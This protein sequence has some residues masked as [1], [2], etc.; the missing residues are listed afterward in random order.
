MA[1]LLTC[2]A[3]S[4]EKVVVVCPDGFVTTLDI[5]D[6]SLFPTKE[7]YKEYVQFQTAA[8]C[9]LDLDVVKDNWEKGGLWE[10]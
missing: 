8:A 7:R 1:L 3:A 9:G 5:P 2:G 6:R 4:A 10:L